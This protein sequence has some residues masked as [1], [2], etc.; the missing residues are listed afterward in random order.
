MP[1]LVVFLAGAGEVGSVWDEQRARIAP[2]PA[3]AFAGGDL[4]TPFSFDAAVAAL[5]ERI[6]GA[7]LRILP[8]GGHQLSTERPDV[9]ADAVREAGAQAR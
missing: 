8:D 9:F 4:G 1:D 3:L 5:D 2:M 6:R 7:E